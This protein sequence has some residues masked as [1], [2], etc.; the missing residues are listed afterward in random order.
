VYQNN[1]SFWELFLELSDNLERTAN[2]EQEAER[3]VKRLY[4]RCSAQIESETTMGI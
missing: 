1:P 2:V 4:T 3:Q